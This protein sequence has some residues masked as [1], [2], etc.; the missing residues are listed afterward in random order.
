MDHVRRDLHVIANTH[1]S[2]AIQNS[3]WVNGDV[4]SEC[5]LAAASIETRELVD[6]AIGANA[7][8]AAPGLYTSKPVDDRPGADVVAGVNRGKLGPP[9]AQ[10][11]PNAP[12]HCARTCPSS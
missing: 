6:C 2:I 10:A 9:A 11:K 3:K 8:A 5:D 4:V 1:V 7:D 12:F